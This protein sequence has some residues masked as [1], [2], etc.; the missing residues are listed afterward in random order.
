MIDRRKDVRVGDLWCTHDQRYLRLVLDPSSGLTMSIDADGDV[1][2][3]R[4]ILFSSV[5]SGFD[6]SLESTWTLVGGP[7]R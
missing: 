2:V 6:D 3:Y 1:D 7:L 4:S 5:P